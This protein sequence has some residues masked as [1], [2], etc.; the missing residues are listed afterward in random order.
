MT[1][2]N[3]K[4]LSMF[5]HEVRV[6]SFS[7]LKLFLATMAKREVWDALQSFEPKCAVSITSIKNPPVVAEGL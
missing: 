2:M 3:V 1:E 5:E 4:K 7:S 6:L